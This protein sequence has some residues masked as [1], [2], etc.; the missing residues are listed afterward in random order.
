MLSRKRPSDNGT[1]LVRR[2][3]R[4]RGG[5]ERRNATVDVLDGLLPRGFVRER[6][7]WPVP[8]SQLINTYAIL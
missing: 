3:G 7:E 8:K 1:L 5:P 6:Q 2:P 4:V